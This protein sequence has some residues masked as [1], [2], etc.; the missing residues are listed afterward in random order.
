LTFTLSRFTVLF[1]F[2]YWPR[3]SWEYFVRSSAS[4]NIDAKVNAAWIYYVGK[5]WTRKP[6]LGF[7]QLK[8]AYERGHSKA[9]FY[10]GS[11]KI[12]GFTFSSGTVKEDRKGGIEDIKMSAAQNDP[13]ALEYLIKNGIDTEKYKQQLIMYNRKI[14][15][16]SALH[17]LYDEC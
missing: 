5:K 10:I 11:L 13:D 2:S 14:E 17:Y 16:E 3:Q 1:L 9:Q 15:K 12:R 4:G 8:E 6:K 7:T